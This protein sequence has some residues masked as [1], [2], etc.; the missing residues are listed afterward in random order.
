MSATNTSIPTPT[1][2]PA[3][4]SP[5]AAPLPVR[6]ARNGPLSH[7]RTTERD[8][9]E[10]V[11]TNATAG[12]LKS[13][14]DTIDQFCWNHQWMMNIGDQKGEDY[15]KILQKHKLK[16][17]LELG[18]YC[19]YSTMLALWYMGEGSRMTSIDPNMETNELAAQLFEFAGVSDRITVYTGVLGDVIDGFAPESF[20]FVLFDHA[21]SKYYSD[22]IL[23]EKARLVGSGGVMIGDNVVFFKINDF[24]L[25]LMNTD[26]LAKPL[27]MYRNQKLYMGKLEYSE[28]ESAMDDGIIKAVVV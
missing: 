24:I 11:L 14:I 22:L 8:L 3:P 25:R 16:N 5:V 4:T 7:T 15:G 6:P 12:D 23:V 10:Y 18:L 9:V 21:K 2:T 19:G 27:A 13:V 1:P 17:G 28:G 20:D 26:Q